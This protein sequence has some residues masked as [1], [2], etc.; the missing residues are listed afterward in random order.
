MSSRSPV[1]YIPGPEQSRPDTD[2]NP[3]AHGPRG[4][5]LTRV[6][7]E[8]LVS[9]DFPSMRLGPELVHRLN[10]AWNGAGQRLHMLHVEVVNTPVRCP[11]C[12]DRALYRKERR[13]FLQKKLLPLL[14]LYPWHCI[15]C[16]QSTLLRLRSTDQVGSTILTP[17][18]IEETP[19]AA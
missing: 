3:S 11:R 7:I 6:Q 15:S 19:K 5:K 13:G 17:D 10:V 2:Q 16:R 18:Q 9:G 8:A 14:G 12:G 4:S 1:F